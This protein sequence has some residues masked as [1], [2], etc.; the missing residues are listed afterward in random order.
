MIAA[1]FTPFKVSRF[2]L[3]LDSIP[4]YADYLKTKHITGVLVNGT[5]GEHVLMSPAERKLVTEVWVKAAPKFGL[6]LMVHVG[7]SSLPDVLDMAS[8]AESLSVPGILCLPDL[9]FKPKTPQQLIDYLKLVSNA[10]PKT[11]LFY[12]HN[13]GYSG[14]NVSVSEFLRCGKTQI[15]TL[16]GIKYTSNDLDEGAKC[17]NIEKDYTI[18]LGAD[19]VFSAALVLGFDS[20]IISS[21]N[22]WPEDYRAIMSSINEGKI[23]V[24]KSVQS[25]ISENLNNIISGGTKVVK[26]KSYMQNTVGLPV[27]PSR[28]TWQQ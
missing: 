10:A 5:T 13:P 23:E 18:F 6:T 12:Y 25:K 26:L 19:T 24:A 8:H 27:G 11:P 7:G 21:L 1:V 3:D 4:V 14:V 9:F 28:L 22:F 15:S 20:A 2:K 17:L 16:S